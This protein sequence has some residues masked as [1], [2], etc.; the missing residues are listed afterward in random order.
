MTTSVDNYL[1]ERRQLLSRKLEEF[2][3]DHEEKIPTYLF[4]AARYAMFPTGKL[5]RPLLVLACGESFGA[6]VENLLA[7]ACAIEMIHTYS[8][9]HDDL[10]CMDD[11][12]YRRGKPSLHKAYPEAHALLTGDFL[13]T[14]AF[15]V[16]A[17]AP[18]LSD[19]QKL[20]LTKTLAESAGAR[21][22][23]GGQTLDIA[24]TGRPTS[25]QILKEI[26]MGKTA[27]LLKASVAFGAIVADVKEQEVKI[28][29]AF[30]NYLGLAFQIVDD[31][32]DVTGTLAILGKQAGSDE[33]KQ[34][35]NAVSLLGLE[36]AKTTAT[37]FYLTALSELQKLSFPT[38]Y[39]EQIAKKLIE[40]NY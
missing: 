15:Q 21:G 9:I 17:E 40:R 12:D 16:V 18:N 4:S 24:F 34:K 2:L 20:R 23:V 28:L 6:N 38:P 22:M 25:W 35:I 30:G 26:H 8:L 37:E 27:A 29:E 13:L 10:P 7:P 36:K 11:D 32:L 1:L 33:K 14:Y 31:I 39:L 3:R 19:N 5:L